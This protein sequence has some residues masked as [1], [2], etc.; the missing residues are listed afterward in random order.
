MAKS[1][2]VLGAL[3]LVVHPSCA[4]AYDVKP[5]SLRRGEIVAE[6]Q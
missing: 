2:C 5:A 4:T 1:R 3:M 6:A